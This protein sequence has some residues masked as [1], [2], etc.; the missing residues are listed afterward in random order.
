MRVLSHRREKE[1]EVVQKVELPARYDDD[2]QQDGWPSK[3]KKRR[4]GCAWYRNV[5]VRRGLGGEVMRA[6]AGADQRFPNYLL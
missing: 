6:Q 4:R 5:L 3:R 1:V 2:V